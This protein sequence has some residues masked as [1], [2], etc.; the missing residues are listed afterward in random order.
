MRYSSSHWLTNGVGGG[1]PSFAFRFRSLTSDAN[2]A[3][4]AKAK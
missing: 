2:W 4:E 3:E 1:L